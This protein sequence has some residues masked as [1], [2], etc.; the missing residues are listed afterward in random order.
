[1][2]EKNSSRSSE[3]TCGHKYGSSISVGD[4]W[5][6]VSHNFG[7]GTSALVREAGTMV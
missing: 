2:E 7:A 1:M 3:Q 5:H 4:L 6:A